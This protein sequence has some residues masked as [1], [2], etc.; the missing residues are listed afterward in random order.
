M[1]IFLDLKAEYNS[2][3]QVYWRYMSLKGISKKYTNLVKALCSNTADSVIA[4]FGLSHELVTSN[5]LL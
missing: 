2:D 5:V 3:S 4:Y 1:I